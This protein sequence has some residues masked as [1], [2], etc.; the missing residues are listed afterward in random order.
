MLQTWMS[1]VCAAAGAIRA[2]GCTDIPEGACDCD[3]NTLDA[4]GVCGGT[5]EGD[6][7]GNGICDIWKRRAADEAACNYDASA[8]TDD[9]LVL[10]A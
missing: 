9:A 2:C 5:C 10:D 7:N 4:V 6:S 1:V 3:G 8:F